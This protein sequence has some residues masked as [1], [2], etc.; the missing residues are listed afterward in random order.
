ME[1]AKDPAYDV[2]RSLMAKYPAVKCSIVIGV[3]FSIQQL[4][5]KMQGLHANY[6]VL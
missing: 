1:T 3:F 5:I 6:Q 2:V 4:I